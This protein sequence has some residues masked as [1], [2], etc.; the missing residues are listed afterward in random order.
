MAAKNTDT[1]SRM[2]LSGEV[3]INYN[4]KDYNFD[5][6]EM[7]MMPGWQTGLEQ[8]NPLTH[9]VTAVVYKIPKELK[10]TAYYHPGRSED[11]QIIE[12]GEIK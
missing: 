3:L 10:G 7:I 8:I 11:G 2:I 9:L 12:I 1:E 6:P 5:H 4:G